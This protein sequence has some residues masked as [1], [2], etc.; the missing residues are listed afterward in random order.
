MTQHI[1]TNDGVCL[2]YDQYGDSGPVVVLIHGWSGSRKYFSRNVSEGL[3]NSG[4]RVYAY[5]QRFHGQSGSPSYGFHV[6]RL[7][8]DLRD[9]LEALNLEEVSWCSQEALCICGTPHHDTAYWSLHTA[10]GV[11]PTSV[12]RAPPRLAWILQ[13]SRGVIAC[14]SSSSC[15]AVATNT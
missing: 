14:V 1:T 6:A 2:A 9:V 12:A 7:A 10:A 5:D 13:A 8:A 11:S 15:T 3:G 4:C